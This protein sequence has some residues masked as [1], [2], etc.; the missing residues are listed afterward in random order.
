M[1]NQNQSECKGAFTIPCSI[2]T[3]NLVKTLSH[4]ALRLL[5]LTNF[6]AHHDIPTGA[7]EVTFIASCSG[8]TEKEIETALTELA[9]ALIA[10][11][12]PQAMNDVIS[13]AQEALEALEG[14]NNK[15]ATLMAE[16]EALNEKITAG[17]EAEGSKASE[18]NTTYH[19]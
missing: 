7:V 11:G 6:A 19:A 12:R 2:V 9:N 10:S 16:V 8:M 3:D 14:L 4:N 1:D 17:R 5:V 15:V 13:Q 18:A